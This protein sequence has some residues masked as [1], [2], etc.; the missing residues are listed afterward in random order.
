MDIIYISKHLNSHEKCI[1]Y[2]EKKRW[3]NVPTCP[4]CGSKKS[5]PKK[6]RHT[7]LSCKNSYSVTVGTVFHSSNLPLQKWLLAICLILSAK[8]GIS[9]MQLSRDICVNKNTAWLL[10]M[11]IRKALD[12][13]NLEMLTSKYIPPIKERF[14]SRKF[15]GSSISR[16]VFTF[17]ISD[18]VNRGIWTQLKRAVIGQYHQIDEYYLHRYV[19]EL[20]FKCLVKGL[21]DRG[22]EILLSKMLFG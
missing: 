7:C 2:L 14:K 6:L 12:E 9:A 21:P 8:K 18:L 17:K 10:Q 19:D 13:N 16:R 20:N 11:K 15:R 22:Y 4:Y 1:Q 3:N 5:S